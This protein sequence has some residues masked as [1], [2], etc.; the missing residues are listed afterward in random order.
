[1]DQE[2]VRQKLIAVFD[3]LPRQLRQAA[4]YVLDHPRDV[5]LMSMREQAREAGVPAA[6]MTRLAQRIGYSGFDSIRA[7][8]A[9]VLRGGTPD[10]FSA[11]GGVQVE[12]QRQLGDQGLA[13]DMIDRLSR[14]IAGLANGDGL[15]QLERVAR[16][17]SNSRHIYCIGLRSSFG[18]A[19]HLYYML[20]LISSRAVLIEGVGDTGID[21][22]GRIGPGDVLV[23]V[24]VAPY[25]RAT[26][27]L[28]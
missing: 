16:L 20:S 12:R 9:A 2:T 11:K 3:Q 21:L 15:G 24:S 19:W 10:G 5:A 14:Q 26:I 7:A 8:H 25:T 13:A 4:R 18:I 22:A 27:K 17:M 1:M 28:A 23:A 6:T